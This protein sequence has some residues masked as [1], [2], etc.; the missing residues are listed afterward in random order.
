MF[1]FAAVVIL[2]SAEHFAEA[3]V[4]TGQE[5]NISEFLLIQWLAPLASEAPELLVAGLY[6]WRLNTNAP[7]GRLSSKVNQWTLL[8]GTLPIVFAVSSASLHGLP[9]DDVQREE[10][11]LTAAQSSCGR[12]AVTPSISVREAWLLFTLFWAQF[13]GGLAPNPSR[14]RTVF[15]AACTWCSACIHQR[16]WIQRSS[17]TASRRPT[18]TGPGRSS[19][20]AGGPD[21]RGYHRRWTRARS[22]LLDAEDELVHAGPVRA[23]EPAVP[24]DVRVIRQRLALVGVTGLFE[25][26]REAFELVRSGRNVIV[27]TG[28]ASGK[29][30][31]Y[32]LA[33][34]TEAVPDPKSTALY[35]FPTKALA[36]DQL[37]QVRELKLP[38][39][40]AGVYDGDTPEADRRSARREPRDDQPGHAPRG[41]ARPSALGGLLPPPVRRGR[42][43]VARVP[44]RVR[45]ARGAR[46]PAA[47]AAGRA[48]R[49]PGFVLLGDVGTRPSSRAAGRRTLRRGDR[50]RRRAR[51]DLRAVEPADRGRESGAR[52]SAL[53]DTRS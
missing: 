49:G 7:W 18:G 48:L 37:R 5:F 17:A 1:V 27:A 6:A 40:R 38:Q 2:L 4:A 50:G 42:R 12:R 9:I 13:I 22:R 28:T 46:A 47:P 21:A 41:I 34:A 32:N 31:V 10:L 52:Q 8:V 20:V 15:V 14:G 3:L 36:R 24:E 23:N 35:L 19:R 29:T 45:I 16:A 44:R 30:L 51:Q 53:T 39:L 26:Q 11:F 43:R 33:F 25:H